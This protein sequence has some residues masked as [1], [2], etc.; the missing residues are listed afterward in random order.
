MSG[1]FRSIDVRLWGDLKVRSLG[2]HAKL[3]FLYA[4]AAPT[5]HPCGAFF[6]PVQKTAR[7]CGFGSDDDVFAAAM[8]QLVASGLVVWDDSN[9][10]IFVRSMHRLQG[11][12]PLYDRGAIRHVESLPEGSPV[13]AAFA[14]STGLMVAPK[15]LAE[16]VSEPLSD[17]VCDRGS[18][19]FSLVRGEE[20]EEEEQEEDKEEE[21]EEERLGAGGAPAASVVASEPTVRPSGPNDGADA[22]ADLWGEICP[23]LPQP[24]RPLSKVARKKLSAAV[25]AQPDRNAWVAVFTMVA[26]SDFLSGRTD[27]KAGHETWE[28]DLWWILSP[29]NREKVESGRYRN[30]GKGASARAD[31]V[32]N[33]M[34]PRVENDDPF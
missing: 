8:A 6:L 28:C 24:R 34:L 25:H 2:S 26:D 30:K 15:P 5:S 33:I 19:S 10:L 18:T 17:R 27:R 31:R 21:E 14:Q 32:A 23:S 29:M 13:I 1:Y 4:I 22:L 12:G 16:G 9:E 7:D 20:E 3:L 11:R